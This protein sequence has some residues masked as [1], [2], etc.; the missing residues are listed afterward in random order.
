MQAPYSDFNKKARSLMR[1]EKIAMDRIRDIVHKFRLLMP[2]FSG[3]EER[4][5]KKVAKLSS[6]CDES[7]NI[8]LRLK[9]KIRISQKDKIDVEG[10]IR[11]VEEKHKNLT[12]GYRSMLLGIAAMEEFHA[13]PESRLSELITKKEGFLE[14][15]SE[16]FKSVENEIG[17]LENIRAE[18]ENKKNGID[19]RMTLLKKREGIINRKITLYRND[20]GSRL[21]ELSSQMENRKKLLNEY[22]RLIETLKQAPDL[23]RWPTGTIKEAIQNR[24]P[25]AMFIKLGNIIK[26]D[27]PLS[28]H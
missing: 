25:Q 27:P 2:F 7:E 14:K 26:D 5:E 13:S 1:E 3:N 23:S 18:L 12:A 17:D 11:S 21:K 16:N 19:K 10:N 28:T 9:S 4:L 8:L 22:S 24:N 20:I 15:L 6:N